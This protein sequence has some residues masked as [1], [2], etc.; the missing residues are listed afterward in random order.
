M[1]HWSVVEKPV[2]DGEKRHSELLSRGRL[3]EIALS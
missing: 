2:Y 3:E 1:E